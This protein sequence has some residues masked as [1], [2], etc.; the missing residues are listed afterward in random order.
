MARKPGGKNNAITHGAY[1]RHLILEDE[2]SGEFEILHQGLIEEW[3]PTG[4][5]EED[6]VHTIAQHMWQK[7]RVD[8]YYWNEATWTQDHPDEE[9]L[10]NMDKYISMLTAARSAKD[11]TET[12]DHLPEFYKQLIKTNIPRSRFNDD[13]SWMQSVRSEM[14]GM[15]ELH[16]AL[17]VLEERTQRYIANKATQLRELLAQK[18]ALDEKLDA[19]IDKAVRRFAQL[20]T[21]KQIVEAQASHAR[22]NDQHSIANQR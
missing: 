11:V 4:T 14:P 9:I 18:I 15:V 22:I 21:F 6:T 13:E 20:K 5:L 12:I 7:R 8:K 10:G 16:E 2:D 3:K 17:V 1:A 19:H